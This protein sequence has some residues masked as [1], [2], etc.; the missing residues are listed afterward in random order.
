MYRE[1]G[2]E[3]PRRDLDEEIASMFHF[4][5]FLDKETLTGEA[6]RTLMSV[7]EV[8]PGEGYRTVLRFDTEEFAASG[9]RT[10]RWIYENPVSQ[11]RLARLA[12]RGA[13]VKPEYEKVVERYLC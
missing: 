7:V 8:V 4:L 10:R 13:A 9:G 5:I 11:E 12:F 1:A 3:L 2:I 6:R